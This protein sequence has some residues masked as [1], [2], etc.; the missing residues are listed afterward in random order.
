[1]RGHHILHNYLTFYEI[2]RHALMDI[3][4]SL[5]LRFLDLYMSF[6]HRARHSFLLVW[7]SRLLDSWLDK[8]AFAVW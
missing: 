3:L 4:T 1:M 5:F 2:Q 6:S 8:I 7:P